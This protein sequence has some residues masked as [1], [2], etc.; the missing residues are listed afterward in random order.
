MPRRIRRCSITKPCPGLPTTDAKVV[1]DPDG[2][3]HLRVGTTECIGSDDGHGHRTATVFV[4]ESKTL[5]RASTIWKSMLY[6]PWGESRGSSNPGQAEWI[7]ELPDDKV[8]PMTT[9]LNII[10]SRF[11]SL[12]SLKS[13]DSIPR[14][15]ELTVLS[16]KYDLAKVLRPWA[17]SWLQPLRDQYASGWTLVRKTDYPWVL[18]KQLWIAWELGDQCLV[19]NTLKEMVFNLK[20]WEFDGPQPPGLIG[21]RPFRPHCT[22]FPC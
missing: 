6:G 20:H 10:H 8:E 19:E 11:E 22:L 2:D 18:H 21:T 4:C 3:L 14:L 9:I 1:V 16:D 5:S 12:E 15:Y 17:K 13:R 7:V